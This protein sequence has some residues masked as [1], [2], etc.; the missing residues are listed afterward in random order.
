MREINYLGGQIHGT[1]K[2]WNANG[3]LTTEVEYYD[4][5]RLDQLSETDEQGNK[6][7]EGWVLHARLQM[8]KPD[9]WWDAQLA[10]YVKQGRDQKHGKWQAWY[11]NGQLKFE[12]NYQY[13]EPH[14]TFRWWYANG[15]KSLEAHYDQGQ[16]DGLWTWWHPNGQ[17][18]IEGYYAQDAPSGRWIW[19]H[20]NGRVA[21]RINYSTDGE[22]IE[23]TSQQSDGQ[24]DMAGGKHDRSRFAPQ[25][26]SAK[27]PDAARQAR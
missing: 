4:G 17:K 23:P 13:D 11:P 27:N 10:T 2:E 25:G 22:P 5:R 1:L 9:R 12:G 24:P 7:Y 21:Q 19:W 16:K 20:E 8:N 18:S 3:D 15:Q 6:Q 26:S 14:G